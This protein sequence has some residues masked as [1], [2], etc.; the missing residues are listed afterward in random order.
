MKPM[1]ELQGFCEGYLQGALS[2]NA[3]LYDWDDW[4]VW[5]GYDINFVGQ[6]YTSEEL[7]KRALL[8]VVYPA[9]HEGDLPDHL[10][11]IGVKK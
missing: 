7:D 8:A 9:G 1:I 11:V 10:C 4:V 3:N 2:C 5:G 6:D